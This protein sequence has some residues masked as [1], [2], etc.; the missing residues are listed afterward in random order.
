MTNGKRAMSGRD[1]GMGLVG[2]LLALVGALVG[3]FAG[4]AGVKQQ[5][6]AAAD[7]AAQERHSAA[8]GTA[9]LMREE[10]DAWA[11]LMQDRIDAGVYAKAK[12]RIETELEPAMRLQVASAV[13]PGVWEKVAAA[14]SLAPKAQRLV[15]RYDDKRELLPK[16]PARARDY[17]RAFGE[18]SDALDPLAS[19]MPP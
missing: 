2:A 8:V 3:G 13:D 11:Q 9:R 7:S 15:N 4:C 5:I 16:D 6:N 14:T 12:I 1:A 10:L 18:A 17:Q 19:E